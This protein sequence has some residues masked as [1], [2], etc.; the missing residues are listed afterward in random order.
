MYKHIRTIYYNSL[1]FYNNIIFNFLVICHLIMPNYFRKSLIT[2]KN[3]ID[4]DFKFLIIISLNEEIEK[5]LKISLLDIG[6]N[7]YNS[8]FKE[9][10]KTDKDEVMSEMSDMSDMSDISDVSDISDN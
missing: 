6:L 3:K 7:F 8:C 10:E 2:Y 4:N 1:V 9:E 5:K